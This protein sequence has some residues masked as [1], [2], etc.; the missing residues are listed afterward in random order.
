MLDILNTPAAVPARSAGTSPTA[1]LAT[2]VLTRP[3]PSPTTKSPAAITSIGVPVSRKARAIRPALATARPAVAG[4]L[5][6]RLVS[7]APPNGM[8]RKTPTV[9]GIISDP[10]S[11]AL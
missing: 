8:P 4:G 11:T 9:A 1:V 10:A 5:P 2:G 6:P 7:R 3:S